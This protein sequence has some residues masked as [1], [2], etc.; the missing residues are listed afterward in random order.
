MIY[1]FIKIFKIK[2]VFSNSAK[3]SLKCMVIQNK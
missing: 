3:K 1:K 2:G